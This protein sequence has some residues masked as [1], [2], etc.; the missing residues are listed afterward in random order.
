MLGERARQ[1]RAS[2]P[3]ATGLDADATYDEARAEALLPLLAQLLGL[4]A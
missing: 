1:G 3:A 4:G 2:A